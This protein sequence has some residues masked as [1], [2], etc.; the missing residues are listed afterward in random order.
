MWRRFG[1]V[2]FAAV[3]AVAVSLEAIPLAYMT[4]VLIGR[5]LGSS[6][7]PRPVPIA[8]GVTVTTALGLAVVT[9]YLLGYQFVSERRGAAIAERR[10][11]WVARW[12]EVLFH[13]APRPD[14]PLGRDA[15]G[16]LLDLRETMRGDAGDRVAELL[17]HYDVA[18]VLAREA[19]S[20]RVATQ[21]E[22]LD[23]LSLA[24]AAE[25]L[26]TLLIGIGDPERAVRVASAR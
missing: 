20:R 14:G 16:A 19:R 5:S 7:G 23:A 22:A 9:T 24:R 10:R 26:P 8:L 6:S 15:S 4:L 12:L 11:R 3:V 25:A 18:G 17:K 13:D 1:D 2:A 21:L